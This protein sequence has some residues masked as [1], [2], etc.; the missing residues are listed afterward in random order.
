MSDGLQGTVCS[1]PDLEPAQGFSL[2]C[3]T[4]GESIGLTSIVATATVS[5]IAVLAVYL[6]IVRNVIREFQRGSGKR[7]I[8]QPMDIYMLSLLASNSF[9][10]LGSLMNI[11][12]I[13]EGKVQTGAFCS[14]Q[15]AMNQVGPVAVALNTLVITLVTFIA[16]WWG[17]G[18]PAN[19]SVR[20]QLVAAAGI[21]GTLWLSVALCVLV[22]FW[23]HSK[24]SDLYFSPTPIWCTI[25][26]PYELVRLFAKYLWLWLACL[27]SFLLY[28]PLS[29]W[30]RGYIT[31]DGWRFRVHK[32]MCVEDDRG[33]RRLFL[34]TIAYP[35]SNAILIAPLSIV[36]WMQN[37]GTYPITST[38]SLAVAAVFELS[39][40]INVLLFLFIR[41]NLLLFRSDTR[42][43][44]CAREL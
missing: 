18:I 2:H 29:L 16:V 14:V 36:R 41:P 26:K 13:G 8:Q 24:P 31:V 33:R 35:L 43:E 28:I 21:V 34:A 20:L 23:I 19:Q 6:L 38:Y 37:A 17:K 11:K 7:L 3:L 27:V 44:S 9:H 4:R 42:C 40:V 15:G 12:W 25:G 1:P 10:S 22:P 39:G 30:S 32:K 5:A